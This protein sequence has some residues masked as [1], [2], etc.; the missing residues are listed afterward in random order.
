MNTSIISGLA[1]GQAPKL[2]NKGFTRI[3]NGYGATRDQMDQ[4]IK[5]AYKDLSRAKKDLQSND[6]PETKAACEKFRGIFN[7]LCDRS[8]FNR[9]VK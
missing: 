3:V 5:R 6:S 8:S 7:Y 4:S 2:S 1:G 9:F